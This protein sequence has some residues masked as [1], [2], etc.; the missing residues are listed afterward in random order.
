[1]R[2]TGGNDRPLLIGDP[3]VGSGDGITS[4]FFNATP[5]GSSGS[6]FGR[7][8]KATFSDLERNAFRGPGFWTVDA[9]VFKRFSTDRASLEFRI[10]V[11]NLFNHV[12]LGQPDSQLGVPG[13]LNPGAGFITST[14][15]QS[16]GINP[17]RNLQFG[18]R[19][20]F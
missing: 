17:Q 13:N 14:A 7:P 20:Q 12:N 2:D 6:A 3:Q 9:S 1:D 15:F 10:E 18:L 4:P 11:R 16:G 5:I 8:A 19:L